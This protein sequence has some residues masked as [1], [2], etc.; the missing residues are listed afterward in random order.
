MSSEKNTT[1]SVE[2]PPSGRTWLF[3]AGL[4]VLGL[5]LG[6]MLFGGSLFGTNDATETTAG[7][8]QVPGVG[9]SGDIPVPRS[10]APLNVGDPAHDFSLAGLDGTQVALSDFRGQ[11]VIVNFWATWCAPCRL[12]MPEFEQVYRDYQDQGLVILALNQAETPE[13]VREFFEDDLGL[14]FTPLLDEETEVA[15]AYG[16]VNLPSTFFVDAEGHITAIHR[17][18]LTREQI[19]A[20]LAETFAAGA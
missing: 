3:I 13:M 4:F 5:A 6:L 9:T 14:S 18:I 8:P 16:A 12:E 20:Y 1:T 19:E 7:L 15:E 2:S 11:P 17:G 10:G